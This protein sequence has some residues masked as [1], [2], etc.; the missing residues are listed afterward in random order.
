MWAGVAP[1][2]GDLLKE[3]VGGGGGVLMA[4]SKSPTPRMWKLMVT[5]I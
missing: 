4:R 2:S 5:K 3:L 1:P